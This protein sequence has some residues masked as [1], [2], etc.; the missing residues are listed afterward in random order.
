[1][2]GQE[3]QPILNASIRLAQC[4]ACIYS[5]DIRSFTI[6]SSYNSDLTSDLADPCKILNCIANIRFAESL[7]API[8]LKFLQCFLQINGCVRTRVA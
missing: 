7:L 6:S 2:H 3:H 8:P 1:M 4:H 5:P